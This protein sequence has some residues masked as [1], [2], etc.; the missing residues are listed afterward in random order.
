MQG[1][2]SGEGVHKADVVQAL[3]STLEQ[4]QV[5][6]AAQHTLLHAVNMTAKPMLATDFA[7]NTLDTGR[8][9]NYL[10]G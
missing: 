7:C 4:L 5:S 10:S 9:F 3:E 1:E 6:S 8:F 2:E